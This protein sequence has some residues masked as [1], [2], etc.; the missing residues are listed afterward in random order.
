MSEKTLLPESVTEVLTEESIDTIE[1]ALKDKVTL[2][3]EAALAQQDELYAEKLQRSLFA[4][5]RKN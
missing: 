4:K 3:V 1:S 2:S 5:S